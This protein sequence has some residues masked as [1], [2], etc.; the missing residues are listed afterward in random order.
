MENEVMKSKK[1][2]RRNKFFSIVVDNSIPLLAA[3]T[4]F[5]LFFLNKLTH[6]NIPFEGD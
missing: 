6:P 3:C 4:T 1:Q 5:Q 2:R